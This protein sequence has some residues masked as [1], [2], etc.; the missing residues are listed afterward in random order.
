MNE[1]SVKV[2]QQPGVITSNFEEI[3]KAA[4]KKA[5]SYKGIIVTEDTVKDSKVDIAELRSYQK[6][7]ETARKD[8]KKK[9]MEPYDLFEKQ[10]KEVVGILEDV[11]VPMD[12]QVKEF[13]LKQKEEKKQKARDYFVE[14]VAGK[15]DLISFDEVFIPEWLN[16]A[17]SFKTI[18]TDIDTAINNR[19]SDIDTIKVMASEVEGKAMAAYKVTKR[20]SDA[21]KVIN[22]Y[23]KQKAEILAREE[24]RRKAEEER[25]AREEAKRKADE[26]R[27]ILEEARREEQRKIEEEKRLAEQEEQKRKEEETIADEVSPVELSEEPFIVEEPHFIVEEQPFIVPKALLTYQVVVSEELEETFLIFLDSLGCNHRRVM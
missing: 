25:K 21:I 7:I 20:L 24:A 14:K 5:D 19:V 12:K 23:E 4:Q 3:K 27:R 16:T 2:I 13:E 6:D 26:E 22:D 8:Y 15:E 9:F 11:I 18:K 1:L 10:C 17:T